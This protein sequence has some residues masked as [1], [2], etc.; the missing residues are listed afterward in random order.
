MFQTLISYQGPG[1]GPRVR[2]V[3][4]LFC[5]DLSLSVWFHVLFSLIGRIRRGGVLDNQSGPVSEHQHHVHPLSE[6]THTSRAGSQ[7]QVRVCVCVYAGQLILLTTLS[8]DLERT[9]PWVVSSRF[10]FLSVTAW[11]TAALRWLQ[12]GTRHGQSSSNTWRGTAAP[13]DR[14]EQRAVNVGLE[15]RN[16]KLT[17]EIF[18]KCIGH[19]SLYWRFWFTA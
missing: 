1:P 9:T 18:H 5:S 15:G 13:V 10:L 14:W 12:L 4:Y 11:Q 3:Q 6:S 17:Y 8:C 19:C 7:H 2:W 16:T